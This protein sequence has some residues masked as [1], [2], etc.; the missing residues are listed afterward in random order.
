MSFSNHVGGDT[1]RLLPKFQVNPK[2]I[3]RFC[4]NA[5]REQKTI[6]TAAGNYEISQSRIFPPYNITE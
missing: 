2:H 5:L 4:K 1:S 3:E 6:R